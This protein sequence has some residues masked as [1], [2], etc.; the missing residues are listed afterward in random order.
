MFGPIDYIV[1]KIEGDYATLEN[2][3]DGEEL[4]IAMALLPEGIDIGTKL[5]YE[6]LEYTV[7]E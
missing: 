5:H 6:M 4:F 3:A 1:K 7:I 2:T